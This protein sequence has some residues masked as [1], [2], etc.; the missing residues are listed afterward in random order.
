MHSLSGTQADGNFEE[1]KRVG[2]KEESLQFW[3]NISNIDAIEVGRVAILHNLALT[4]APDKN[5]LP[6]TLL[7][8]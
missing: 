3:C 6:V 2:V 1:P 7:W 4:P 8:Y 5:H